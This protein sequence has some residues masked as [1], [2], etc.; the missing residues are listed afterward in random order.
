MMDFQRVKC[1]LVA[2]YRN[3]CGARFCWWYALCKLLA[4]SLLLAPKA[5]TLNDTSLPAVPMPRSR[6]RGQFQGMTVT[7]DKQKSSES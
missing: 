7:G 4:I 5:E 1:S 3:S 6:T 2:L